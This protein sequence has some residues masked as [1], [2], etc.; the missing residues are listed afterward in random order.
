MSVVISEGSQALMHVAGD[1]E[2]VLADGADDLKLW[3]RVSALHVL[4]EILGGGEPHYRLG[5]VPPLVAW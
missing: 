4:K 2:L 3:T 1:D 5:L